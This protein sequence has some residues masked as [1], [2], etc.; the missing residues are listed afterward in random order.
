MI[1]GG[2]C[3]SGTRGFFLPSAFSHRCGGWVLWPGAV[4]PPRWRFSALPVCCLGMAKSEDCCWGGLCP[5]CL[6]TRRSRGFYL[7][8]EACSALESLTFV[9]CHRMSF[10]SRRPH[11]QSQWAVTSWPQSMQ[12]SHQPSCAFPTLSLG[13]RL[14]VFA[15]F[16]PGTLKGDSHPAQLGHRKR[17]CSRLRGFRM[18]SL[19]SQST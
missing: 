11:P 10:K 1:I 7:K 9:Y 14:M 5:L 2:G 19:V 4:L 18:V 8:S 13:S 12:A 17:A 6:L 16:A 15:T 3:S